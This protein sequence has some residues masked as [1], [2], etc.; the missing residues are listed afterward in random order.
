MKRAQ[1][2]KRLAKESGISTA[3]AADQLDGILTGIL[4]R[5]RQGHSASLPGLGTF[6]PGPAAEFYFEQSLP[7]GAQRINRM[8]KKIFGQSGDHRRQDNVIMF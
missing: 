1:L 6:L 8:L 5:V 4:R 7:T 3:A 2:V